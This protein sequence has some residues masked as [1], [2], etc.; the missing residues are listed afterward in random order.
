LPPLSAGNR[1]QT[2]IF[3]LISL[4]VFFLSLPALPG[5]TFLCSATSIASLKRS[6]PS[7]R[8][9]VEVIMDLPALISH[10]ILIMLSFFIKSLRKDLQLIDL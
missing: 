10:N 9:R 5:R 3:Q 6:D 4:L 2:A 1:G 8:Q 7:A